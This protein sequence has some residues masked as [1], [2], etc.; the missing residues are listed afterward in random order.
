MNFSFDDDQLAVKRAA[1]EFLKARYGLG[2]VRE[3][4]ADQRGFTDEQWGQL[5]QLGW[6]GVIVTEADGG[7]G[8]GVVELIIIHEELGY[9]LAPTPL[10]S[11]ASAAL[12][13]GT[14]ADERQ[15]RDWLAPIASGE[16]RGTLAVLDEDASWPPAGAVATRRDGKLTATKIAVPD[17]DSADL[18]IVA[19]ADGEHFLVRRDAPGLTVEPVTVLDPTRKL[20]KVTLKDVP[21]EPLER[22]D[23][24]SVAHAYSVIATALAAENVGVAQ[25]AMEMAVA[26]ARERKQFD[27]PV[28]SYQAV[29]HRC[30]QMLLEVEGAR[31]LTY[32]AAW[33]LDHEPAIAARAASMAKAYASDAGFRVCAS[34]LQVHGGIAFTWEHD[35]HFF[36]KRAKANAHTFGD[37]RWHRERVAKLSG[38]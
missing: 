9:A 38:V 3:L 23:R 22:L 12:L 36:L 18:L 32:G 26:Y 8:L 25:R 4:A 37:A 5:A 16:L 21:S 6:P 7:L 11:T 34:A 17:A 33:A 15:R 35:L 28:G 10:L 30:A 24:A 20:Y 29:A 2:L 14:G 1:N 19:G 31:S 13:L 27:R